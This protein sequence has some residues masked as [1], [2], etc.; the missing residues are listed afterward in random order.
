MAREAG[1]DAS[2]GVGRP[3][4][5]RGGRYFFGHIFVRL[6]DYSRPNLL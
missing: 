4:P 3:A 5:E 6:P 2:T 1:A